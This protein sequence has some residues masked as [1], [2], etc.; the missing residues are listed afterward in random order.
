MIVL[1]ASVDVLKDAGPLLRPIIFQPGPR[2]KAPSVAHWKVMPLDSEVEVISANPA[3][4]LPHTAS[5]FF[6]EKLAPPELQA[7]IVNQQDSLRSKHLMA[8]LS[9][10]PIPVWMQK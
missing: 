5:V 4:V 9:C 1:Y 7:I 2:E 8:H 3:A 10:T 6:L